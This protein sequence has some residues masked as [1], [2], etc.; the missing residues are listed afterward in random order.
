MLCCVK[1]RIHSDLTLLVQ[2]S[3]FMSVGY[4]SK[5]CCA[6]HPRRNA[7]VGVR[8]VRVV[9]DGVSIALARDDDR[10]LPLSGVAADAR[11]HGASLDRWRRISMCECGIWLGVAQWELQAGVCACECRLIYKQALDRLSPSLHVLLVP[12]VPRPMPDGYG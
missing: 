11:G 1:H 5:R 7:T 3:L 10:E 12:R 9:G 2:T 6:H 8:S 4:H